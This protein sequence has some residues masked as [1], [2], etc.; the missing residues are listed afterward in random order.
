VD[1]SKRKIAMFRCGEDPMIGPKS[2]LAFM[3]SELRAD[4]EIATDNG[5]PVGIY[6]K[7][8]DGAE[9]VVPFDNVKSFRFEPKAQEE[10]PVRLK[11]GPKPK[12]SE[13]V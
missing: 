4:V 6:V 10:A 3:A 11:P 12:T 9:H 2:R 1:I 13:A 7:L 8:P 5:E